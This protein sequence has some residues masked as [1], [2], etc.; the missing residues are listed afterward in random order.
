MAASLVPRL[1]FGWP[2]LAEKI[3]C[4]ALGLDDTALECTKL[5]VLA[6]SKAG[7]LDPDLDL[8]LTGE[9]DD[10]L[11]LDWIDPVSGAVSGQLRV[12]RQIYVLIK[13][14]GDAWTPLRNRLAGPLYVDI[15]RV[16]HSPASA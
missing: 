15:G 2:A 14:G 5:T 11:L 1:V 8:R 10:Q 16:L 7:M 13:G 12:P 3:R 6:E 9:A 4:Q